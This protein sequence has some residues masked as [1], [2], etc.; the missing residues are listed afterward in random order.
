MNERPDYEIARE[1][2]SVILVQERIDIRAKFVPFSQSRNAGEK[3][4]SLNWK[5]DLVRNADTAKPVTMI[6]DIDYSQGAAYAPA[7]KKSWQVWGGKG[8]KELALGIEC[9]SGRIAQGGVA[10]PPKASAKDIPVPCVVDII[11]SLCLDSDVLNYGKFD[12]WADC[13][14]YDTDSRNAESIYRACLKIALQ[15]RAVFGDEL[16]PKMQDLANRL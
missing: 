13:F 10:C 3:H 16:L 4:K 15:M 7:Y 1:E 11:S 14:G 2:L 9:E 6:A 5:I 8:W 12:D